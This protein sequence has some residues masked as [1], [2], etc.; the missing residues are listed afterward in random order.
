MHPSRPRRSDRRA[1]R[2]GWPLSLALLAP[3]AHA[4]AFLP[5]AAVDPPTGD[6]APPQAADTRAAEPLR[7]PGFR[8]EFGP[9]RK[10]GS[11]TLDGRWLRLG[12]GSTTQQGVV[13]S[14]IE[15]ASYLWQPWFAQVR[16]GVGSLVAVD[17]SQGSD[18]AGSGINGT[19]TALT[20]RLGLML[21]PA[22]RFPFELRV[23]VGDSR[24]AGDSITGDIQTRR[25]SLSQSYRPPTSND[26][27]QLQVQYS[28]L[29]DGVG[30]D[31]LTTL[32]ASASGQR[33]AH[34]LE[35]L[36]DHARNHSDDG[37]RS[38]VSS[39]VARHGFRPSIGLQV[40][41]TANWTE[42]QLGD[43]DNLTA[44]AGVQ[45][46][47]LSSVATWRPG[48]GQPL[49][50][51]GMPL[52]L[53]GSL[54]WIEARNLGTGNAASTQ[55]LNGTLG[56]NLELSRQWR[57]NGSLTAAKSFG[58]N[59]DGPLVLAANGSATWA[60]D[61]VDWGAWRY[62]PSVGFNA[63]AARV[64][65]VQS[66][67]LAGVQ[68]SHALARS[69]QLGATESLGVT[70][71][72]SAAV[73]H[74]S[75]N[76]E[77]VRALAHSAALYW[78]SIHNGTSQRFAS[79]SVQDSRTRAVGDGSY[80][81][82]NLQLSQRVQLSRYT[83]WSA[84]VTLQ[85]SRNDSTE[86]D[87]FSGDLLTQHT[88]WQPFYSGSI[89]LEQQRLFE[90]PRLRHTLQLTVNSQQL[91]RRRLGDIDAPRQRISASL[92]SRIDYSIGRLAVR[93]TARAAQVENRV[94]AL[95]ALRAV[96]SF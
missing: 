62:S 49:Y 15:F 63:G 77:L 61:G 85:A 69:W 27:L 4:A 51:E 33:G 23:D 80:Q 60:P 19:S 95:L 94:V 79:L 64:D 39:L 41:T 55:S 82:V 5:G 54:R 17:R 9:W 29:E 59:V 32:H 31:D 1:R 67:W 18:S 44:D 6:A 36:A 90:V 40:D 25:V 92:E 20:G 11:V 75:Q 81:F 8:F 83:S 46:R 35:F 16:L 73:L 91:E 86:I 2:W 68:G 12:N 72:Q 89:S 66:R 10:A 76:A 93:F 37:S 47:Q 53:A 34:A 42:Q 45:V 70:L 71:T 52:V 38:R 48:P 96:R 43:D 88:G 28:R 78:Q 26:Q 84:N 22:S 14:D 13:S 56:A 57:L 7:A 74:E 24:T 50:R 87:A 58:D 30:R 65:A 21:F 3:A